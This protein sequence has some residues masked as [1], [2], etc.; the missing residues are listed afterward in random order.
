METKK[1]SS[2]LLQGLKEFEVKEKAVV[3]NIFQVNTESRKKELA[4][5]IL[6]RLKVL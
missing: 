3:E 2:L 5:I 6:A 1:A 4:S